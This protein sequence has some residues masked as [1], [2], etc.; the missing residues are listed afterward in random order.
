MSWIDF[1]ITAGV[2]GA[3]FAVINIGLFAWFC[4]CMRDYDDDSDF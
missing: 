3:V 1:L 4:A 2:A